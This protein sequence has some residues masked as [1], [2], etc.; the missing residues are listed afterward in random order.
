MPAGCFHLSY[1]Y[2]NSTTDE[3][4]K[5]APHFL[6]TRC[7]SVANAVAWGEK[8]RLAACQVIVV[9]S[10]LTKLCVCP[11]RGK[12][13]IR[14]EGLETI[15]QPFIMI[16]TFHTLC[17]HF[18]KNLPSLSV[19]SG[20]C[21][22]VSVS[23]GLFLYMWISMKF[24][25][26]FLA[27]CFPAFE[28]STY[29]SAVLFVIKTP[30][31]IHKKKTNESWWPLLLSLQNSLH[32]SATLFFSSSRSVFTS[33]LPFTAVSTASSWPWW[34]EGR[35]RPGWPR[36]TRSSDHAGSRPSTPGTSLRL[37]ARRHGITHQ[38]NY[39]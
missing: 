1:Y 29:W 15:S 11:P 5:L 30:Q 23:S 7:L 20:D 32:L 22:C 6:W 27:S 12:L 17:N 16:G 21:P 13:K 14:P 38:K 9:S 4:T 24:S 28:S 18:L 26:Q 31:R 19:R 2:G 25:L 8:V 36:Q 37:R 34:A 3:S 39:V 33:V 35:A 10:T